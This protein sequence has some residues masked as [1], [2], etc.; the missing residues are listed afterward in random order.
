[1]NCCSSFV[2]DFGIEAGTGEKC[3]IHSKSLNFNICY[4][5]CGFI[6]ILNKLK[7]YDTNYPNS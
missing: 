5:Y 2:D 6:L 3:G 4:F 7:T 1:M